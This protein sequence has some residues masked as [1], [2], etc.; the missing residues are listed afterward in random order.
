MLRN[1]FG[2][3]VPSDLLRLEITQ[4]MQIKKYILVN[5]QYAALRLKQMCKIQAYYFK[6]E[7]HA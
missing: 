6:I 5:W 7:L 2:S 3:H 4:S 1:L